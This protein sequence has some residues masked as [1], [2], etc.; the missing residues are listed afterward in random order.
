[1]ALHRDARN[2]R[3]HGPI[4]ALRSAT[5]AL[6]TMKLT[7]LAALLSTALFAQETPTERDA[8]R[9]VLKKM[10]AL[11]KVARRAG[12]GGAALG[13]RMRLATG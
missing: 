9:E 4:A 10:D 11:E 5:I 7:A 13:A 2:G 6:P 1:M 3:V 12:L 8:A